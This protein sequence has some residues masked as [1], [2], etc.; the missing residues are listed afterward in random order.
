MKAIFTY[1]SNSGTSFIDPNYIGDDTVGFQK[2]IKELVDGTYKTWAAPIP[3]DTVSNI[4]S[5]LS[6]YN[7]ATWF[8]TSGN[9]SIYNFWENPLYTGITELI[10]ENISSAT[11]THTVTSNVEFAS[12]HGL[13]DSQ[14]MT[15]SGFDGSW[16]ALNGNDY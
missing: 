7:E 2:R 12:N 1:P 3:S 6:K 4:M 15:L 10:S 11:A 9:N 5:E 16:S 13:Y 14:L 8:E